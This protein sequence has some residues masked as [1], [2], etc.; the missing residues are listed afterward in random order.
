[1]AFEQDVPQW[2]T[3]GKWW[4]G[5]K[6]IRPGEIFQTRRLEAP[7]DRQ[8]RSAGGR[9]SRTRTTRKRG[10]YVQSRP[11][12]RDPSDLA[13]DATLRAAAPYQRKRR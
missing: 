5:G 12:P 2:P 8:T 6:F 3:D 13:F 7:L 4:E 9:R 1:M 11:S 10:R